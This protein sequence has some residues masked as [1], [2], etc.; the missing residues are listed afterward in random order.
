MRNYRALLEGRADPMSV[1][2]VPPE[3]RI[4]HL[5]SIAVFRL[6]QDEPGLPPAIASP[7][8]DA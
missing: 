7:R 6:Q 2:H 3:H 4:G 5:D 1:R 8:R